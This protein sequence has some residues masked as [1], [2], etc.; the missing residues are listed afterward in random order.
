MKVLLFLPLLLITLFSSAQSRIIGKPIQFYSFEVT[1][2]DFP[3]EMNWVD[4]HIACK[5]LGKGWRLPNEKEL[6]T[7]ARNINRIGNFKG[8]VYWSFFGKDNKRAWAC[9]FQR[10]KNFGRL[11][12]S[13]KMQTL[14]VRAVRSL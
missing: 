7:L 8:G 13:K 10:G 6:R 9:I 4:A 11:V 3:A 12:Y 14:S 2:Y 5:K 1:Q